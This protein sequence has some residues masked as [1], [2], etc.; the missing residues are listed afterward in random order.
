MRWP[1]GPGAPVPQGPW[2]PGPLGPRVPV[3]QG[4]WAP[5]SLCPRVP[6]PQGPDK[7]LEKNNT[8]RG[9]IFF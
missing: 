5:G 7:N 8:P 4:P 1:M 3:P 6:G 9:V 2:A